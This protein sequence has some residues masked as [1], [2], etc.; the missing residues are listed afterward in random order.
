MKPLIDKQV[1]LD[2]LQYTCTRLNSLEVNFNINRWNHGVHKGESY[3]T[4][5]CVTNLVLAGG[6]IRLCSTNKNVCAQYT[7][8]NLALKYL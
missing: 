3:Q 4:A 5:K 7:Y 2:R 6:T 1:N 8:T